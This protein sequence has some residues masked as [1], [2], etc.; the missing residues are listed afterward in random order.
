MYAVGS[1]LKGETY[2]GIGYNSFTSRMKV[3]L[4]KVKKNLKSLNDPIK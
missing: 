2:E 4:K 3:T 1:S